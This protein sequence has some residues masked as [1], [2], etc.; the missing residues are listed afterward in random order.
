MTIDEV[1]D[2]QLDSAQLQQL[3]AGLPIE[4]LPSLFL[5]VG[6]AG[7]QLNVPTNLG[8]AYAGDIDR[9]C[10]CCPANDHVLSGTGRYPHDGPAC[11]WGQY[12]SP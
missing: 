7:N 11:I 6:G 10:T 8:P 2:G 9:S 1:F 3:V 12:I 5:P 4:F